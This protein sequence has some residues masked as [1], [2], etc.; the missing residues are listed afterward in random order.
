MP[1]ALIIGGTGAIGRATARRLLTAGWSV[2]LTGRDP[3][4]L[5][6][7]IAAAGG[8]FVAADHHDPDRLPAVLGAGADLIVDCLCFTA[9]DAARLLPLAR[10][11]TSTVMLSSKAVYVDGAGLHSNSPVAPRFDGPISETQPT[12]APGGGDPMT[13]EGY[14][15]NK[16]AAER[17][18]L[19]S[20]APV[21]VI[22]PSKV[23]GEGARRPREWVFVK[24]ALDRRAALFLAHRGAGVDHPTAA[25]N[26]AT[27]IEVVAA[28]PGRRILNSA[29]P[30]APSALE[31]SRTIAGQLDHRWAEVLLDDGADPALGR[32]PWDAPHPIVLDTAAATA[33]GHTP[34]GDYAATVREEVEW[35]AGAARGGEG[36]ALLRQ[37]DEAYF[38]PLLDYAAEDRHL[39]AHPAALGPGDAPA[40]A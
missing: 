1:R 9:D 2:D 23:H 3:A 22:R 15:A 32:H 26:V 33:L 16:V 14:G 35:L 27:L 8:R 5:P 18:L 12:V 4:H 40:P 30:D 37:L 7:D 24:R 21:T 20:G 31:I 13:R 19:D 29:D 17:V 36:A 6:A 25:A 39:V 28:A 34:A 38:G 10:A 11:A